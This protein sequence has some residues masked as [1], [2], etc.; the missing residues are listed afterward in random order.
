MKKVLMIAALLVATMFRPAL[1]KAADADQ[2]P[3]LSTMTVAEL[4]AKGDAL[5]T[6]RDFPEAIRYYKAGIQK[7]PKN[8]QLYN[9]MGVAELRLDHIQAAAADFQKAVK[10]DDKNSHALNNLGVIYFTEKNYGKAVKYYKKALAMNETN[11]TYHSNLGTAWF[12]QNKIDRAMAEYARAIEIDPDVFSKSNPTGSI[13]RIESS[14]DRAR[15]EF[16]LAKLFAQRGDWDNCFHWLQ[17][18]KEDGY[19][20]MKEVYKDADF[21]KVR[22]DPRLAQIVPPPAQAGF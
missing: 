6:Q 7:D 22:Q 16:M 11:A 4:E 1:T 21:A 12:S 8:S 20:P 18:A 19:G 14:Q 9:K 13:A 17:K 10:V 5:R 15:Y 3:S 2:G